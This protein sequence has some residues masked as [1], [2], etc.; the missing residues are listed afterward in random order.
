MAEDSDEGADAE[1]IAELERDDSIFEGLGFVATEGLTKLDALK[2]RR[3]FWDDVRSE[4]TVNFSNLFSSKVSQQM[5]TALKSHDTEDKKK[6]ATELFQILLENDAIE[7]VL[8]KKDKGMEMVTD[9]D[10]KPGSALD[11]VGYKAMDE[12]KRGSI[13]RK[14]IVSSLNVQFLRNQRKKLE[15]L[16]YDK[17]L[18]GVNAVDIA[19]LGGLPVEFQGAGLFRDSKEF[20]K[21]ELNLKISAKRKRRLR[22]G[23]VREEETANPG[24]AGE[25]K[26]DDEDK[27]GS[28]VVLEDTQ[29]QVQ[30]EASK[31]DDGKKGD[32]DVEV[33]DLQMQ[34]EVGEDQNPW[35]E[36][37]ESS[38]EEESE[39]GE[40][41]SESDNEEQKKRE[42]PKEVEEKPA[43]KQ[44]SEEGE[45]IRRSPRKHAKS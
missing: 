33:E 35:P 28:E 11:Y 6:R 42:G 21:K 16:I 41:N 45:K 32:S 37:E 18:D 4:E 38:E 25:S 44:R 20:L 13:E 22:K 36:E 19:E 40:T 10:F 34:V 39:D 3:R 29:K 2:E 43:K 24:D 5:R 23:K 15:S 7:N 30:V 27:G 1:E 8:L 31:T 26:R 14:E 12:Y 9:M 17:T